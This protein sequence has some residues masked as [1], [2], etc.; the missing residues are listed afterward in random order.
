V[1]VMSAPLREVGR[2]DAGAERQE[3]D[4]A[5]VVLARAELLL[6][7]P[8]GVGVIEHRDGLSVELG[9]DDVARVGP[10]PALVDVRCGPHRA[11]GD[12]ARV[13]DAERA[14]PAEL[15]DDGGDGLGDGIGRGGLRCRQLEPVADQ[16][17]GVEIHDAALD[18]AS[19]DVDSEPPSL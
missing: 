18:A 14:G 4:H 10:D 9:G 17:S 1:V 3:H 7:E 5:A 15:A 6:G 12:D 19:A 2:V 8:G 11:I 16:R 13:G